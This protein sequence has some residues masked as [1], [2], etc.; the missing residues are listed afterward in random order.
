MNTRPSLPPRAAPLAEHRCPLCGGPNGCAAAASG[1]FRTPCWCSGV[2]F[3]PQALAA[4]PE[5]ARGRACLCRG[6]AEGGGPG[7]ASGATQHGPD[8]GIS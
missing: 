3:S 8:P 2:V 6:C 4:V 7:G 1:S 5:A